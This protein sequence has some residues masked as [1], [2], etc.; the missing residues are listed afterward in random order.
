MLRYS[1]F[2]AWSVAVA[3]AGLSLPLSAAPLKEGQT[4]A[5]PAVPQSQAPTIAAAKGAARPYAPGNL[6]ADALP[7]P[8]RV[9]PVPSIDFGTTLHQITSPHDEPFLPDG[10]G[11]AA[12]VGNCVTCHS[13]RYVTNQP[14]F[15]RKTW[16]AEVKKMAELYGA[17][18]PPEDMKAITEYLV[19]FHGKEDEKP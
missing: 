15:P 1:L 12:F 9:V 3:S 19:S 6:P 7:D 5:K 13:P 8:S 16:A 4:A 10:P 2:A 18:I 14:L 11:R 17:P